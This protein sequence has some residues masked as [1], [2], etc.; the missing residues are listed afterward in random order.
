[1]YAWEY[2]FVLGKLRISRLNIMKII[3]YNKKSL[4][5]KMRSAS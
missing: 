3:G 5:G 1:M 4:K 2:K